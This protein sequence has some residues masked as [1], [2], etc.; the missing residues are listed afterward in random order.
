MTFMNYDVIWNN[1]DVIC[2]KYD[3]ISENYDVI[4][5]IYDVIWATSFIHLPDSQL[6]SRYF[7]VL[8][9]FSLATLYK[10]IDHFVFSILFEISSQQWRRIQVHQLPKSFRFYTEVSNCHRTVIQLCPRIPR[11]C[12]IK[13]LGQF[14][15]FFQ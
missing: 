9:S 5:R 14:R 13:V 12:Q 6:P 1:I 15:Q 11:H 4:Q 10:Q 3:I 2:L 8:S 7:L